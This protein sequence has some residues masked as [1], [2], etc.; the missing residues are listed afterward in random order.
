MTTLSDAA[1][2]QVCRHAGFVGDDLHTAVACAIGASGGF[3]GYEHEIGLGPT[4]RYKGLFGV[5][6]VEWPQMADR[7]LENPY[8]AAHVAYELTGEHGWAWCP[9]FRAG[10]HVHHLRRAAVAA[11]DIPYRE[12]EQQPILVDTARTMMLQSRTDLA[13][14]LD[15]YRP[16]IWSN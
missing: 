8:E 2:G 11:G 15:E 4:A 13:R 10:H 12:H 1:L 6:T 14:K 3:P 5:D 9:V 16:T 7:A